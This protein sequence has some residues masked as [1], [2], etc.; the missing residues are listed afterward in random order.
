MGVL[1]TDPY[2]LKEQ[3]I[4]LSNLYVTCKSTVS[5]FKDAIDGEDKYFIRTVFFYYA[6]QSTSK[7]SLAEEVATYLLT[8]E[9]LNSNIVDLAYQKFKTM[10]GSI[11][12]QDA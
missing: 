4:T 8:I 5:L 6:C 3:G 9:E 2:E 12:H 11:A 1:I 10:L 7:K